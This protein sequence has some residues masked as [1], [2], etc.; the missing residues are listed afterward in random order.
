MVA[1]KERRLSENS[2]RYIYIYKYHEKEVG[3]TT[4]RPEGGAIAESMGPNKTENRDRTT[5]R[6]YDGKEHAIRVV[7]SYWLNFS[8]RT[9]KVSACLV[10]GSL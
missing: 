10:F 7:E 3:A 1:Q 9:Q 4:E 6:E 8:V 5:V 2:T